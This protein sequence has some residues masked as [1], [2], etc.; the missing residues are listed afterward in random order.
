MATIIV[1]LDERD[2]ILFVQRR[3]V[4]WYL[5]QL[6]PFAKSAN[7]EQAI[8]FTSG[9]IRHCQ[10]MYAGARSLATTLDDRIVRHGDGQAAHEYLLARERLRVV[11]NISLRPREP[12]K[13]ARASH[14]RLPRFFASFCI[15]RACEF[16]NFS[17]RFSSSPHEKGGLCPWTK[18]RGKKKGKSQKSVK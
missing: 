11:R 2:L 1:Q 9:N 14:F 17:A 4:T 12:Q 6:A 15:P 7:R 10:V 18:K 16:R 13:M 5:A 3:W 8:G